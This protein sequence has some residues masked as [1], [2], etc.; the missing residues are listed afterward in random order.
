MF[1]PYK[2]LFVHFLTLPSLLHPSILLFLYLILLRTG[3]A[4]L[5]FVHAT[6]TVKIVTYADAN[7]DLS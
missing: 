2:S 5:F 4:N 7:K 6:R 3:T 1:I